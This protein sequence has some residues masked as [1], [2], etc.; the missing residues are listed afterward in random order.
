MSFIRLAVYLNRAYKAVE[1][2]FK[3]TGSNI[4]IFHFITDIIIHYNYEK[5]NINIFCL[6][7]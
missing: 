1:A 6:E 4:I 7:I 2:F 5:I 3:N